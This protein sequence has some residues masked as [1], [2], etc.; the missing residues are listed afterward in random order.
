LS[1]LDR[2]P[3]TRPELPEAYR[4][5]YEAHYLR[6]REGRYATT[7]FSQR[8]EGWM[9]RK[10]AADVAGGGQRATTL[11]IGAGTLNQLR[12]EPPGAMYDIVEPFTALF[13][14]SAE[15]TRVRHVY[16]DISEVPAVSRYDRITS[17]A[18]FEHIPD[19]PSVVAAAA[20]RLSAAGHLRV[21]IPGEGTILW[22]LG[23]RITGLEFKRRYGLDYAVLMNYEHVNTAAEIE[24]V[25]EH[26]FA[27]CRC[28]VFG[29]SRALAFYRFYDC[30]RPRTVSG[31]S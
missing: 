5:I 20:R 12:Y 13:E 16:R 15:L 29:V 6:N 22:T 11:E 26:Y 10:V 3:K 23:T 9:H 28:S 1:I 30:S 4:K 21:A 31:G 27:S 24:A 18:T 25:L 17:V 19:L 7:S 14:R 8:L 2:F